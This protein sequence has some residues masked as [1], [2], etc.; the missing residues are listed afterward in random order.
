MH[1]TENVEEKHNRVKDLDRH[2]DEKL[3]RRIYA[4]LFKEFRSYD[5]LA[6]I[7]EM[8]VEDVSDKLPIFIPNVVK[9][10]S[11]FIQKIRATLALLHYN[12]I[13][14]KQKEEIADLFETL[15]D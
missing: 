10:D 5:T 12:V 14:S 15:R 2:I 7:L 1:R 13:S 4:V 9:W 3:Y 8:P 11:L 6:E